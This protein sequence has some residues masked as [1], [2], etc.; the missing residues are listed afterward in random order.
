ML[1][2]MEPDLR[3][4]QVIL[5]KVTLKLAENLPQKLA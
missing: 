5:R 3:T 2:E 4:P 1:Q